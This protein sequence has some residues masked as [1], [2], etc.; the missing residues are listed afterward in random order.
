MSEL[1]SWETL[2]GWAAAGQA[3]VERAA[4]GLDPANLPTSDASAMNFGS[5]GNSKAKA[6]RDIWGCGQGIGAV[7]EIPSA[8]DMIARLSDEY[9]QALA[10][11]A[12][13]V[14]LT[15]R[16]LALAAE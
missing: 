5:G 9:D 14:A 8:A 6:W 15:Q 4:A 3:Q 12:A 16:R 7:K 2:T 13:K 1:P 10:E 11:L